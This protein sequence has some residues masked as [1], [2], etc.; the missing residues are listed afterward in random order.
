V[1]CPGPSR[2]AEPKSE[3]T[4]TVYKHLLHSL[5]HQGLHPTSVLALFQQ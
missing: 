1:R 3:L 4:L 5:H 2:Q